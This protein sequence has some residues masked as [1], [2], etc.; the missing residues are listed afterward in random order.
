MD[1]LLQ[2]ITFDKEILGGKPIVRGLR[3]PLD[4]ILERL[5]KGASPQEIVEDYP[6]LEPDEIRAA[7]LYAHHLVSGETVIDR[8]AI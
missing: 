3:I 6:I 4:M 2:R 1:D 7:L 8:M 5:A